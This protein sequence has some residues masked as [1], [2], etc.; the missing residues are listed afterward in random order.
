MGTLILKAATRLLVGLIL[1][2]SVYL[3]FRGHQ[4]P[5]G[6]FAGAL[7]AGTA[8][9]L[10]AISEGAAACRRALRIDP[11]LLTAAGLLTALAAGITAVVANK[12]FLTGLW[13][14]WG[15]GAEAHVIIGTPVIFDIGVYLTVLGTILT[16]VL[17]LE[18]E[19]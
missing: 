12:P 6:G 1:V 17:A 2:F 5:G 11:R 3:L 13:W 8:F 16:L 7:V 10:F 14:G 9:A 18:E 15:H 4:S 19:A